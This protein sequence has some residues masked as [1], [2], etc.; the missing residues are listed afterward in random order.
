MVRLSGQR[1]RHWANGCGD[2][3]VLLPGVNGSA[4]R[5]EVFCWDHELGEHEKV[6]DDFTE[7]ELA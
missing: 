4:L 3:L 1:R 5:D 2:R 6:A 7:L